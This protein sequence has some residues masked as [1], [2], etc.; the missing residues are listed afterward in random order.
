MKQYNEKF[1]A[2]FDSRWVV[3]HQDAR[4][5]IDEVNS[6][7]FCVQRFRVHKE[8][9]L[10][11]HYHGVMENFFFTLGN[12]V[13]YLVPVFPNGTLD[14]ENRSMVWVSPGSTLEVPP[15]TAHLFMMKPGAIFFCHSPISFEKKQSETTPISVTPW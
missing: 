14:H 12:G 6:N 13:I 5:T 1:F 4:R 11:N 8:M 10:G 9:G 2:Q 15:R 7:D 3:A